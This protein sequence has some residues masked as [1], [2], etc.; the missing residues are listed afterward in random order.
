MIFTC[1][2]K[3]NRG[4]KRVCNFFSSDEII[5]DQR[6]WFVKKKIPLSLKHLNGTVQTCR[7]CFLWI[8]LYL[9]FSTRTSFVPH[10]I[11]S[12][13]VNFAWFFFS[14]HLQSFDS[15][16]RWV[17]PN[18]S[19]CSFKWICNALHMNFTDLMPLSTLQ[20][21]NFTV[22][23]SWFE[24][25]CQ[26][27]VEENRGEDGERRRRRRRK[28]VLLKNTMIS[29]RQLG[30]ATSCLWSSITFPAFSR[31]VFDLQCTVVNAFA[32]YCNYNF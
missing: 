31:S 29:N 30:E 23:W 19:Y 6:F 5:A 7:N 27:F 26:R 16:N 17:Y 9:T 22:K 20:Y 13:C 15:L 2:H 14:S 21:L 28:E 32:Q 11:Y 1:A 12:S 8:K 4:K 24:C 3:W 25:Q 10:K 18:E